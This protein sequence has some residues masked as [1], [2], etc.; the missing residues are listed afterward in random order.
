MS[1]TSTKTVHGPKDRSIKGVA[2]QGRA[3]RTGCFMLT[4]VATQDGLVWRSRLTAGGLVSGR[5]ENTI[6]QPL[7]GWKMSVIFITGIVASYEAAGIFWAR[8]RLSTHQLL[9][10][11][12][13]VFWVFAT[14]FLVPT[15]K[16]PAGKK[17]EWSWNLMHCRDLQKRFGHDLEMYWELGAQWR[18]GEKIHRSFVT[19]ASW[20]VDFVW[21]FWQLASRKQAFDPG[22]GGKLQSG[23]KLSGLK[24]STDLC[25]LGFGWF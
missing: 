20:D 23:S 21:V 15:W 13:R 4:H 24:D 3:G 19:I 12:P 8:A 7:F 16:T 14:R 22:S 2:T 10:Q 25:G 18:K 6:E 9:R 17:L 1:Q 5:V 11:V